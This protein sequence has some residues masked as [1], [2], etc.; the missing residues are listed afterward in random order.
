MKTAESSCNQTS[1]NQSVGVFYYDGLL[2]LAA[3]ICSSCTAVVSHHLHAGLKAH[4]KIQSACMCL[5][6]VSG[7]KKKKIL[8]VL[9]QRDC[10]TGV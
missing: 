1:C 9:L 7:K 4:Q 3:L 10:Q 8:N 6:G 5:E 2:K